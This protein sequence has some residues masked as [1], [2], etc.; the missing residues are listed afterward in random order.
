VKESWKNILKKQMCSV[1]YLICLRAGY[2]N[3]DCP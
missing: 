2:R 1:I 3:L